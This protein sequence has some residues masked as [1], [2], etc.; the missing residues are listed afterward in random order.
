MARKTN[1]IVYMAGLYEISADNV[2]SFL[3][4]L[5]RS[6]SLPSATQLLR[7]VEKGPAVAF[8]VL[9]PDFTPAKRKYELPKYFD[10]DALEPKVQAAAKRN[11]AYLTPLQPMLKRRRRNTHEEYQ[12]IINRVSAAIG[13]ANPPSVR[14]LARLAGEWATDHF[15][16]RALVPKSYGVRRNHLT[17]LG[18]LLTAHCTRVLPLTSGS[19]TAAE[20]RGHVGLL[21]DNI[22]DLVGIE[23][24]K[25]PSYSAITR[26]V[27]ELNF[28]DR[29]RARK[30]KKAADA[31][32]QF[33]SPTIAPI[34]LMERVEIDHH[35]IDLFVADDATAQALGKAWLTLAICCTSR[36]IV[37][38][39]ITLNDPSSESIKHCLEFAMLPKRIPAKLA[40]PTTRVWKQGGSIEF[41]VADN[42]LDFRGKQLAALCQGL[43]VELCFPPAYE[44]YMRGAVERQFL[45]AIKKLFG[46][47]PG[48]DLKQS[49]YERDHHPSEGSLITVQTLREVFLKYVV[50]DYHVSP[51]VRLGGK[52]P[53]QVWDEM[54]EAGLGPGTLDESLRFQFQGERLQRRLDKNGFQIDYLVYNSAELSELRAQ[55]GEVMTI[56][57]YVPYVDVSQA[58]AIHPVT[59]KP[60]L[61]PCTDQAYSRG[62]TRHQHLAI[63]KLAKT[64]GLQLD[65]DTERA[66]A[67]AEIRNYVLKKQIST[68]MRDRREA[69]RLDG[70]VESSAAPSCPQEQSLLDFE[71]DDHEAP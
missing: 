17:G 65:T 68:R 60:F 63:R 48:F 2:V 39:W 5:N 34:R 12:A 31:A 15:S 28:I 33:F 40:L 56:E 27:R 7:A 37:G 43:G 69:K 19:Y 66:K 49:V 50:D 41:L 42:G 51:Q 6:K 9:K 25:R 71:G 70:A 13:D 53:M 67:K 18:G 24:G 21:A 20:I 47:L 1:F 46:L 3:A 64:L 22:R 59:K 57:V 45:T 4:G 54:V 23:A 11:L 55:Y 35:R 44:P 8:D 14:S 36:C 62:L 29:N 32:V 61:V 26:L 30:G 38:F 10:I 52:S 16:S 58:V